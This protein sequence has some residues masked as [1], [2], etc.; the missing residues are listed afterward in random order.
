MAVLV[1]ICALATATC[2]GYYVGRRAGSTP[3]TWRKR[4]SRVAIGRLA[5][6]FAMVVAARRIRR[7]MRSV[8]P[9]ELLRDGVA[10]VLR[11]AS[12]V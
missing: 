8:E 7:T 9:V 2:A 3:P 11:R 1:L 4:T 12:L 5:L 6:N 10:V